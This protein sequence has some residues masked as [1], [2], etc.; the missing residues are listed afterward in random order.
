ML[1]D[2]QR[3]FDWSPQSWIYAMYNHQFSY[4]LSGSSV[5][6]I[7]RLYPMKIGE[8][9]SY[10]DAHMPIEYQVAKIKMGDIF[11]YYTTSEGVLKTPTWSCLK[12][13]V[14]EYMEESPR[15]KFHPSLVRQ[16]IEENGIDRLELME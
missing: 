12:Y 15:L 7:R 4:D 11:D 14:D 6:F 3:D 1:N 8:L 16:F 13:A 9:G 2:K 10:W 5:D